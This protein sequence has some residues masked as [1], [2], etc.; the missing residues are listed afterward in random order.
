MENL[1][2]DG[3]M[4]IIPQRTLP[5]GILYTK[6]R[7]LCYVKGHGHWSYT[8]FVNDFQFHHLRRNATCHIT[9]AI[10]L[11][12]SFRICHQEGF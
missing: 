4:F 7:F 8:V 12:A 3:G 2:G 9:N 6:Q 1:D 5:T 10:A 11:A